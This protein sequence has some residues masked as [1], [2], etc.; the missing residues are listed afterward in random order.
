MAPGGRV[1]NWPD[2]LAMF[3]ADGCACIDAFGEHDCVAWTDFGVRGG[4]AAG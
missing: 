1:E 4:S 2:W 3:V